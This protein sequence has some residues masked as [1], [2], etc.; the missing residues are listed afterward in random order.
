MKRRLQPQIADV[1]VSRD[2][3]VV[4]WQI[5]RNRDDII[6]G[7]N[8]YVSTQPGLVSLG[9]NDNRL[10]DALYN[11]STYPGDT[12]GDIRSESIVLQRLQTGERYYVHVRTLFPRG[13]ASTPSN[14]IEFMPRPQGTL[15]LRPR[16]SGGNDGY[17]FAD[18]TTV[19]WT[20]LSND[21]YL[22]MVRDTAYLAS[23]SRL[24]GE[25]RETRFVTLGFADDFSAYP[26]ISSDDGAEKV[27]LVER[28]VIGL[29]LNDDR[30][31]K[32]RVVS[33]DP[34]ADPPTV[35]FQYRYQPVAGETHF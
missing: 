19:E 34:D 25:L 8:V 4:K 26:E 27:A 35:T 15:T 12:D 17:S 14:E 9:L 31:A 32:L 10:R 11:Q 2:G 28:Q 1:V 3:A 18:D 22:Y 30:I 33:I 13:E 20:S 23:P 29:R 21:I 16:L 5:D 24:N 6:R 7:Y